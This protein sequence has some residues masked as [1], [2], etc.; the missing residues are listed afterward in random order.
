MHLCSMY[1]IYAIPQVQHRTG[2][3][4]SPVA[5]L[6]FFL[7]IQNVFYITSPFRPT[8][9][10]ETLDT[11]PPSPP[12][13]LFGM[14][15]SYLRVDHTRGALSAWHRVPFDDSN[16]CSGQ[17]QQG[18]KTRPEQE[19]EIFMLTNSFVCRKWTKKSWAIRLLS[20]LRVGFHIFPYLVGNCGSGAIEKL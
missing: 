1:Y 4:F 7:L 13:A 8:H 17:R 5:P 16:L 15:K 10:F 3:F 6:V 19:V 14:Y 9:A 11:I 18:V 20:T 2:F 12:R